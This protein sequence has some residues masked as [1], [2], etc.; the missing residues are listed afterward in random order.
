MPVKPGQALLHYRIVDKLGEGGMGQV[1]KAVDTTLER[2]VALKFLPPELADHPERLFR[3][4]REAKL[5]ATLNHPNIAAVYGFQAHD[6]L[7]FVVMEYVA[8]EDLAE[9]IG[10][11][12]LPVAEA[13]EVATQ[14]AEA[15]AA[16]HDKGVVHRDLKPANVRVTPEGVVK[17]LDFGL[18]KSLEADQ[19]GSGHPSASPTRTSGGTALG[20]ILGT[21]GYM[22]PEQARGK[23]VARRADMWAFG[24]VLYEML[25]GTRAFDAETVADTLS[26][27]I[28]REPEW[29]RLPDRTPA[30]TR[31]LLRRCLDK[32]LT[33]RVRDASDARLEL[34]EPDEPAA[35]SPNGRRNR[36]GAAG[37]VAAALVGAATVAAA[38]TLSTLSSVPA[39]E[40]LPPI[41]QVTFTGDV[42]DP[43]ALGGSGGG[44]PAG[45]DLASDGRTA[46]YLTKDRKRAIL[47]DLDGGGSQTLYTAGPRTTLY[48]VAWSADGD[49]VY[50][51]TWPYA[52]RVLSV[53]RFGGVPRQELDLSRLRVLNGIHV[54]PLRDGR[55]LV[56]GDQN[57][58]YV[59]PDPGS[60]L[61]QGRQLIGEGAF[62]I[63]GMELL[64]RFAISGDGT[65]IAFQGVDAAGRERS[66]ISDLEG[67]AEF[68]AAW[69][70]LAPLGWSN[71][72]RT[73]HLWRSTG[74]DIGDLLRVETDPS[75]GRPASE[76]ELVYPRLATRSALVSA[77]GRRV[78]LR[79]GD[80][81][82]NLREF[83]LDG[84]VDAG[85][86][87]TRVRTQ[88]TGRWR[89]YDVFPDGTL[90]AG[91][92][93][94]LDREL[95]AI[96]DDDAPRGLARL[97][98][99]T[100]GG[101]V[102]ADGRLVAMAVAQPAPAILIHDVANNRSRTIP[103][104]EPL[105]D[106]D[107][108]RDGRH[109]AGMT[110]S[111]ADNLVLVD[112][113][114]GEARTV[115]LQCRD[116]CEFAWESIRVGPD[117]PYAAVTSEI[118]SWV[119]NVETGELRHVAADTWSVL[120]WWDSFIYFLRSTG[121]TDWPGTVI[122][123]VPNDGGREE[124]L[125]E[126]PIDCDDVR[127]SRDGTE[128]ICSM[129]ESRLD[130]R[131]VDGLGR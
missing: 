108:F 38:W 130:L 111:S 59:G 119:V 113:E 77:D 44:N 6:G 16:A 115:K 71:D 53:P 98:R 107:W 57:T 121:Q 69:S 46:V 33:H 90:L 67:K 55:W 125:L 72:G 109:I 1:W 25:T 45:L 95:F 34:L 19:S 89:I 105:S 117:W 20:V 123:R 52:D 124:R 68:V 15:L 60:L 10:R 110:T 22:S 91:R 84:T 126:L 4:D 92:D 41:L 103:V 79:V 85:D 129:E 30:A 131:L 5:L 76:P 18:A 42:V 114:R 35:M 80:R 49:R 12:P 93:G 29:D 66:G 32:R 116:Q 97:E 11:G 78:L 47:I 58:L 27:V 26:A 2:E 51:M 120:G 70:G 94:D 83:T 21:A 122:F 13:L 99:A 43:I 65:H 24:C 63:E 8:G 28:N 9:R 7:R 31:R 100:T 118:D 128:A 50:L 74:F 62:R 54:R 112:V 75:T 82:A 101:A 104:P 23:P 37:L 102:S 86:N 88:G 3:F 96:S 40:A 87:P 17:V 14:I 56:L 81:V 73:L 127:I 64:L 48:D 39:P 106:L 61:T 36:W